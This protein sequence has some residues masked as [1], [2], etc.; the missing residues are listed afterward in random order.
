M[1]RTQH[2]IPKLRQAPDV[3]GHCKRHPAN[4]GDIGIGFTLNS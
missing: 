1:G 4:F 2:Q 3:S